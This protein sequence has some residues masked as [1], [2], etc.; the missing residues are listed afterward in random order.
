MQSIKEIDILTQ[1]WDL[2]IVLDGCRY[3]VFSKMYKKYFGTEGVLKEVR[4]FIRS[5]EW[6]YHNF[7]DREECKDV[8]FINH[9]IM[10]NE[11]IPIRKFNKVVDVWKDNWNY[12]YGTVLPESITTEALKQIKH[13]SSKRF[14]VHYI[15][16]HSPFLNKKY[17]GLGEIDTPEKILD[18]F[19]KNKR[20]NFDL[21]QMSQGIFRKL[22]GGVRGWDFLLKI[23]FPPGDYLGRIYSMYGYDE[24]KKAYEDNLKRGFENVSLLLE[25]Y[26][27]NVLISSDHSMFYCGGKR[28]LD[29]ETIPYFFIEGYNGKK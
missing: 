5:S 10:F 26:K 21:V 15:T 22:V 28:N 19:D 24:I 13:N 17:L 29:L 11:C 7:N 14:I 12:E 6:M 4:G 8:I 23:G 18:G 1:D 16:P 2:Y 3:D 20:T 25:K 27:G 9:T